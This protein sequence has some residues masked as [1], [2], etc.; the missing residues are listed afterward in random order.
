MDQEMIISAVEKRPALY[1]K[2]DSDRHY[3]N[4]DYITLFEKKHITK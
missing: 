4:R 2:T 3:S 1:D